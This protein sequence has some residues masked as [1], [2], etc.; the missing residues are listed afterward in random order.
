MKFMKKTKILLATIVMAAILMPLAAMA[1]ADVHEASPVYTVFEGTVSAVHN[2][3]PYSSHITLQGDGEYNLHNFIITENTLFMTVDGPKPVEEIN[4]GDALRAYFIQPLFQAAIFPPQNEVSVFV[5]AP[6]EE[7]AQSIFFGRFDEHLVSDDNSLRLN[8]SDDTVILRANGED[9][10]G[11][12]LEG[13][14]LAVVYTISTR[15]IP[16]MTTPELVVILNPTPEMAKDLLAEYLAGAPENGYVDIAVGGPLELDQETID[17]LNAQLAEGLSGAPIIVRGE[18][19]VAPEPVVKNNWVF[20]PLR[21]IAEA[22]GYDVF[23]EAETASIAL[24]AGIRLQIGSYEYLIGRM[25]P[26]TLYN[27]PIIIDELTYVPLEFFGQV[28]GYDASFMIEEGR[29][30]IT[31]S[32]RDW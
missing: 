29:G 31:I 8:I 3:Y 15:S 30:E 13:R 20:L 24:G 26:I 16:A 7:S 21:A 12:T 23:W 14:D 27:A 11:V 10:R 4:V 18:Q 6:G 17:L 28:L 32:D 5:K 1:T 9:G 19:I 2:N 25:A 22:L